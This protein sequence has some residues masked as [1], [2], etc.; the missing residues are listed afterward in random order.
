VNE[1]VSELTDG[2]WDAEVVEAKGTVLVDF[3]ASWCPP[4]RMIAPSIESLAAEF[5]GRAKVGKLNV[6]DNPEVAARYRITSIPTLLVFRGGQLVDQR[7][8]ALPKT[9]I[10]SLI[11]RQLV[12]AGAEPVA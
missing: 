11:E 7:V 9:E 6:D 3:W 8:G 4:C 10:A 2:N 1:H 12:P 5:K